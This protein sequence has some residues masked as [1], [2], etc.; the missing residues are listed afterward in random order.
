V[1]LARRYHCFATRSAAWDFVFGI[2]YAYFSF[3]AL[4]W[5]FP[6]ATLTLRAR[7]WLTR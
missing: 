2:L 6:D 3:F 5:I 7:G 1:H 4:T